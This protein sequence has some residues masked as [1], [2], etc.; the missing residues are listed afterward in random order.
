MTITATTMTAISALVDIFCLRPGAHRVCRRGCPAGW[1]ANELN[2]ARE[3]QRR[4][5]N[6]PDERRAEL[7]AAF[8]KERERQLAT[9][10]GSVE[11]VRATVRG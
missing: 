11:N 7:G 3:P 1:R 2:D 8:L 4:Q 6:V 9:D 5:E 10:C